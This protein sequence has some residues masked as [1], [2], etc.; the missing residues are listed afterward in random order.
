MY[1][2]YPGFVFRH[3]QTDIEM[4]YRNSM[5]IDKNIHPFFQRKQKKKM[6]C[7]G[8]TLLRY[9]DMLQPNSSVFVEVLRRHKDANEEEFHSD[10]DENTVVD[11]DV[12]DNAADTDLQTTLAF[13]G[14]WG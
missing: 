6:W 5:I 8:G 10:I 4:F 9:M 2:N 3:S 7:I 1:F 14:I 11:G 12:T 13:S